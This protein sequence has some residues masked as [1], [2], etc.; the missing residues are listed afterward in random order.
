MFMR[1]FI[2]LILSLLVFFS[3]M[4]SY[5]SAEIS[6]SMSKDSKAYVEVSF[7]KPANNSTVYYNKGNTSFCLGVI[8]FELKNKQNLMPS[9]KFNIIPSSPSF[10]QKLWGRIGAALRWRTFVEILIGGALG[11]INP[12]KNFLGAACGF[13]FGIFT[14][15]SGYSN[16]NTFE[17]NINQIPFE[18]KLVPISSQEASEL[19][20]EPVKVGE[21]KQNII[22]IESFH[23]EINKVNGKTGAEKLSEELIKRAL[24]VLNNPNIDPGD[25]FNAVQTGNILKY[26]G[27]RSPKNLDNY[28]S[29][30]EANK[31]NAQISKSRS[32]ICDK[33]SNAKGI[34]SSNFNDGNIAVLSKANP[35]QCFAVIVNNVDKPEAQKLTRL[36]QELLGA[37]PLKD[38]SKLL[39]GTKIA[40]DTYNR[41][42][43]EG[44]AII[45]LGVTDPSPSWPARI[46]KACLPNAISQD[47][48][49]AVDY[50]WKNIKKSALKGWSLVKG[51]KN[52]INM[53]LD[54]SPSGVVDND[55]WYTQITV[56]LQ[57][58]AKTIA[59]HIWIPI[60]SLGEWLTNKISGYFNFEVP[61]NFDASPEES[62]GYFVMTD[63]TDGSDKLE[64]GG[65][66][67]FQLAE[68]DNANED[69]QQ[70]N[71]VDNANDVQQ[72]QNDENDEAYALGLRNPFD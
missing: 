39:F 58:G 30:D 9:V 13:F 37:K 43:I 23:D 25:P 42:E 24:N 52:K 62:P 48:A 66:T 50:I 69:Q 18:Y 4:S 12:R 33:Y 17:V 38:T 41:K 47:G 57:K 44:D 68:V 65:Q 36:L 35:E 70:Q 19:T 63:N 3:N 15:D 59:Y 10:S 6:P 26:A 7:I 11:G 21:K 71:E 29:R 56:P 46:V 55:K 45:D 72:H 32:L 49:E 31:M 5:A 54:L 28:I 64:I 34:N 22:N 60:R 27:Y 20:K 8:K 51:Q 16:L 2:A 53:E 14:A 61:S 67:D 40:Y 1:R